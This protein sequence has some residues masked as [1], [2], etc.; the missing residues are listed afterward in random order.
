MFQFCYRFPKKHAKIQ[1]F[2][3]IVKRKRPEAA[4]VEKFFCSKCSFVIFSCYLCGN[5]T[6]ITWKTILFQPESTAQ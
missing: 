5:N 3:D 1:L 4:G 6:Y 2:L